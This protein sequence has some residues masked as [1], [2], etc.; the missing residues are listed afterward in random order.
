[1]SNSIHPTALISKNA[2]IGDNNV[3]GP[4]CIIYDNVEIGDGNIFVS[5][6]SIGSPAE[7]KISTGTEGVVIGSRN[8]FR[9]FITINQG[10]KNI[11]QIGSSGYFMR[12][13]HF[14]HDC[15][16][17]DHVTLACN[18]IIGG[19]TIVMDYAN[20][21]LGAITHQNIVIPPG[22]MLGAGAVATKANYE[23]WTIYAGIPAKKLKKNTVGL[24]RSGLTIQELDDL[25]NKHIQLLVKMRMSA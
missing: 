6:A 21:G 17:F 4:Y 11:T 23:S 13:V 20:L 16:I 8:T 9:E 14:G 24:E 5:H 15:H 22:C 10:T 3:F 25:E 19:H 1:M 18:S 12:G 7:H 2:I